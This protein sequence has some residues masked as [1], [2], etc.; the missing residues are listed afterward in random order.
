MTS[1]LVTGF[2]PFADEP[3]NPSGEIAAAL[4]GQRVGGFEVR[5]LVLPVARA[6]VGTLLEEQIAALRPRAVLGL[7]LAAERG[8]VNVEQVALNL[9]DYAIPDALGAQPRGEPVVEG[10]PHAL[11]ATLPVDRVLR[12]IRAAGV[13]AALSRS[14]GTYLCN[15]VFYLLLA[16]GGRGPLDE[17]FG[18]GFLHLPPLP[19]AVAARDNA[20]PSMA[21]ETSL[22]AVRTT[23]EVV[24]ATLARRDPLL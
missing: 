3:R 9:D 22:R 7:G 11:L 10:G 24:A 6:A 13:P 8:T 23:L 15:R 16:H 20:R 14:A 5:S 17:R 12:A 1:I 18:V 2:E 19:E 4:A 21:L